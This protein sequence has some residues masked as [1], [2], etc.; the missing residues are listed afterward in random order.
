MT[1]IPTKLPVKL[2]DATGSGKAKI[3]ASKL[4]LRISQLVHKV[5]IEIPKAIPKIFD[6]SLTLTS[7]LFALIQSCCIIPKT[8]I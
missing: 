8:L 3:A 7:H 2:P 4:Q 6:L 5:P 1:A